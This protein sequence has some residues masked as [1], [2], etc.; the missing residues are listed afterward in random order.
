V[1]SAPVP[2]LTLSL[3]GFWGGQEWKNA[4]RERSGAL[5]ARLPGRSPAPRTRGGA[6]EESW[7][8]RS[9]YTSCGAARGF[10]QRP[11][12]SSRPPGLPPASA[13]RGAPRSGPGPA[14]RGTRLS[15]LG[16]LD[17]Y[18][19]III[20]NNNNFGFNFSQ[21][22]HERREGNFLTPPPLPL[23]TLRILLKG[24]KGEKQSE[25]RC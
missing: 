10:R 16:P 23:R 3:P 2:R 1:R 19:I 22:E 14:A 17:L 13:R 6:A 15:D 18:F 25:Q 4:V 5:L 24:R 21:G 8:F 20:I 9:L 12:T 7:A 11:G